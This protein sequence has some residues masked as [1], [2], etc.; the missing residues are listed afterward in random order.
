M[1]A[2]FGQ[3]G[4]A[5]FFSVGKIELLIC[6][7]ELEE[8]L[9]RALESDLRHD[10]AHFLMDASHLVEA[11]LV[12]FCRALVGRRHPLQTHRIIGVALGQ[13]PCAILCGR[14]FGLLGHGR[15]EVFIGRAD[16]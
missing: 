13:L 15:D 3:I 12:D 7:H 2:S 5:A 9:Q 10:P 11:E 14:A 16:R 6:S 1:G 8:F 4:L